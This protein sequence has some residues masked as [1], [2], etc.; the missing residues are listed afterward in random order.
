MSA[1]L[2][3]L[4]HRLS[5]ESWRAYCRR[6]GIE[7]AHGREIT[8]VPSI[9]STIMISK[10]DS[11]ARVRAIHEA[12]PGA[13]IYS[14]SLLD[15][16]MTFIKNQGEALQRYVALYAGSHRS[17]GI[18]LP[19][20]RT[21][22][23]NDGS[24]VGLVREAVFRQWGA[25]PS[26]I[27]KLSVLRP[28][29]VHAHFGTSGPSGLAI[30]QALRV[31]LV[32]TFHGKDAT[33]TV[34]EAMRSRRG[35]EFVR[36]KSM[37]IARASRFI[38]VSDYIRARLLEQGFPDEKV[39]VHR[40]G[41]DLKYFERSND[42]IRKPVILFVGRFVE[43][44]G[45]R[46]LIEAAQLLRRDGVEFE[47][48]LV[49]SGPLEKQLRSQARA[50]DVPVRFT[51]FLAPDEIRHWLEVATVVAVPSVTA[52]DGDS[53]GLP[54][55]LLEAQAMGTPVVATLHS[56]IPEG[57]QQ[58]VTAELVNEADSIALAA[59]LRSFLESPVKTEK[60]GAAA[61]EFVSRN[62]DMR[63]Q[64]EGLEEIYFRV[65]SDSVKWA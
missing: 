45:A 4:R 21:F 30:A 40:N 65:S 20:D 5:G 63:T 57:V 2:E 35:R 50:A 37:L 29:V 31:P 17:V 10:R 14:H 38:A 60:F 18:E 1:V 41:I 25:A 42:A 48:V 26:L 11:Q 23:V 12:R 51:G 33:M 59:K 9:Y 27:R 52:A 47:L 36:H 15:A 7:I 39:I 28:E 53:E 56:G 61:R 16:S 43:K 49:G 13:V 54:T 19:S 3:H 55:V 32:V 6:R 44:K 58:G 46:Y 34:E 62:F 22:V 24:L 8:N 64:I